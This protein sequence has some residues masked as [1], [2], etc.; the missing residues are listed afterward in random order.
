MLGVFRGQIWQTLFLHKIIGEDC[1]A[2]YVKI[3]FEA[4]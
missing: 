1:K 2:G 3:H 4:L